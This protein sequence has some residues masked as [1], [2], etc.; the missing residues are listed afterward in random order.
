MSLVRSAAKHLAAFCLLA[1]AAVPGWSQSD[2]S[3][4]TGTVKDPSGSSVPNAKV[5]VKNEGTGIVRNTA[6]NQAGAY[7]A[8]NIPSGLYSITVEAAG[9]KIKEVDIERMWVPVE[10][11]LA[12]KE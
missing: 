4:I 5:A 10:I 7:T 8:T 12:V 11:V 6:T 3:T 9:F 2:L 1:A